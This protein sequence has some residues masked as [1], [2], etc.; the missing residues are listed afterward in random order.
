MIEVVS[1]IIAFLL[2]VSLI[3]VLFLIIYVCYG[4]LKDKI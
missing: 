1:Y 3:G 4:I 2:L